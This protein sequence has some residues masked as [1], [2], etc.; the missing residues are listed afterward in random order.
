MPI[1]QADIDWAT[2]DILILGEKSGRYRTVYLDEAAR[3]YLKKYLSGRHDN[4]P[5]LF[6][7]EKQPYGRLSTCGIRTE[8]KVIANRMDMK[9]RV[10]PHK[11]RKTLGMELKNRGADIGIIQEVLGHADP[12]VTGQYYAQS[13]ADTLRS[14]RKRIA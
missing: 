8:L 1:N 4:N 11:M 12:A 9:C 14:V 2:G 5:A 6:A 13:T 10:Y 3:Y 7:W